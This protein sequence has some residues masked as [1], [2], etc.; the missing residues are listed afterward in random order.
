M[1]SIKFSIVSVSYNCV[2][3][4]DK[5][6]D[7]V[8]AQDYSDYQYILIDGKSTD[9]TRELIEKR[10][11]AFKDCVFISERDQGIYDAM[12]K[13]ISLATGDYVVFLNM[14]DS[15]VNHHILSDVE[16][17]LSAYSKPIILYGDIYRGEELLEYPEKITHSFLLKEK[18]VCHQSIFSH[19]SY[20]RERPYDIQYRV[21]ADRDWFVYW[22]KKNVDFVHMGE[23]LVQ[24]DYSPDGQSRQYKRFSGDSLK[25][26]KKYY[27]LPGYLFVLLKRKAGKVIK[28]L[29]R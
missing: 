28:W 3:L 20:L 27:G 13:A 16:K 21:C 14:G 8:L 10:K 6:M 19:I 4:V 1:S 7:S 17:Q 5:T 24:Y 23:V 15:F 25:I 9:G 12:N 26:T 22:F 29:R 2:A 11:N 18:M